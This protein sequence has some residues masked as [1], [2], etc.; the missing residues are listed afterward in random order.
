M[1]LEV[2]RDTFTD[3]STIGKLSLGGRFFCYTLEDFDRDLNKDGDLLDLGEAKVHGKTAIPRGT[4]TV[5]LTMSN[6]FKKVLPLIVAVPG[7][8]GIRIHPGNT[9][10]HTEGCLLV[11]ESKAKDFI[12]GSQIAFNKLMDI[13]TK[14]KEPIT[15]T[16]K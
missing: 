12:G 3:K 7:F 10:E 9:A 8:E 2:I 11:G 15:I 13:L 1:K 14:S 16:I 6:R 4:Y 5:Q